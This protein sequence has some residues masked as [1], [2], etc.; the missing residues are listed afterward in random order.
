M[1]K[2]LALLALLLLLLAEALIGP[3]FARALAGP[4]MVLKET[5][6]DFGAVEQGK[7]IAHTFIVYN[8]GAQPLRIKRVRP[9]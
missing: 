3:S 1:R 2:I 6:F 4:K 7:T 9:G 5:S 8:K